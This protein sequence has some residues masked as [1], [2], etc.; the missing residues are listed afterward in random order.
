MDLLLAEDDEVSR[1]FLIDVLEDAGHRVTAV[2]NGNAVIETA[3]QRRF[4][5]LLIDLNLP[6]CTGDA[7]LRALR[8]DPGGSNGSTPAIGSTADRSDAARHRLLAAG[9]AALLI[10]PLSANDV[11]AALRCD[12][13]VVA[14]DVCSVEPSHGPWNDV[15]ALQASGGKA[16][17]VEALRGLLLRDLPE[18]SA[19]IQRSARN[20]LPG[21]SL[22]ELHKLRAACR[23]CGAHRLELAVDRLER[24]LSTSAANLDDNLLAFDRAC[25]ELLAVGSGE[26][27]RP[28]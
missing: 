15:Q 4:D 6:G 11:L 1:L 13:A 18:Q 12:G 2:T 17:I 22:A 10:K 8:S 9:F 5:L 3:R 16:A 14:T 20:A 28:A 25:A 23:F 26:V 21:G 19:T 7:A 24:S 27:V